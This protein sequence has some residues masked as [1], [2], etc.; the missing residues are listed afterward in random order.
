MELNT[1]PPG[2]SFPFRPVVGSGSAP[3]V[4]D[5]RTPGAG[6]FIRPGKKTDGERG[7]LDAL[8]VKYAGSHKYERVVLESSGKEVEMIGFDKIEQLQRYYSSTLFC[9]FVED[10]L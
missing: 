8:R 3:A 5:C 7:F 2:N 10:N 4:P 1:F 9:A 6:S